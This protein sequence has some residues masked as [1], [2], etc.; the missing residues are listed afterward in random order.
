M[1][2]VGDVCTV[3]TLGGCLLSHTITR[4]SGA[5]DI[6]FDVGRAAVEMV[7]GKRASNTDDQQ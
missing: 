5:I 3:S 7:D 2:V 6:R 1:S 4:Q